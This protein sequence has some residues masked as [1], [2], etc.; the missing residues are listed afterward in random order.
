MTSALRLR[1]VTLNAMGLRRGPE[2]VGEAL[3]ELRADIVLLQESGSRRG[4]RIVA[5]RARMEY[6]GDPY[7]PLRRRVKNALLIRAPWRVAESVH[8]RFRGSARWYPRGALIA[9]LQRGDAGLWTVST[10]LGLSGPERGRHV[11]ELVALLR[12]RAPLVIGGDLNAGPES[13]AVRT[14]GRLGADL[15][16]VAGTGPGPTFPAGSPEARIDYVFG[17]ANLRVLRAE[18][19]TGVLVSDHLPVI[20]DLEIT[21]AAPAS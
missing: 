3:R 5:E 9:H 16:S 14:L 7:A 13:G 2:R 10:H 17:S 11:A 1:V 18:V 6:V 4:L 8:H 15:W 12:G 20:V 21:P 19:G